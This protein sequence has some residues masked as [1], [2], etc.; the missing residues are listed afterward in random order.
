MSFISTPSAEEV[1]DRWK[2]YVV[3]GV[4][5]LVLGVIAFGNVVQATLVTT[6]FVGWLLVFGGIMQIVGAF[7]A[8]GST[9]IR[10]L[11][12]I[13][14]ILFVI[15]GWNLVAEPLRGTIALTIVV[16]IV[17][18]ADGIVRLIGAFMGPSGHR[19][20]GVFLGVINIILGVWLYTGIPLSGLALGFFLGLELLM[21]GISWIVI[22]FMAR[23]LRSTGPTAAAPA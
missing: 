16:S 17:L 11:M 5:L 6:I 21:A 4:V 9:G 8:R 19:L 14:A 2:W 1:G 7:T 13:L 12:A 20:L 10:I 15:V 18:I 3:F 22:G 23:S